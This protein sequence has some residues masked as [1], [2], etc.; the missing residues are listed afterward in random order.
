MAYNKGGAKKINS[1]LKYDFS[2]THPYLVK[3]VLFLTTKPQNDKIKIHELRIK[4]KNKCH[5]KLICAAC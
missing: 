1:I 5:K 3:N 4:K 2:S